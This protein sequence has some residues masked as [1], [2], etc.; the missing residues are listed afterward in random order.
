MSLSFLD[1]E[2]SRS[3]TCILLNSEPFVLVYLF[4]YFVLLALPF[5]LLFA[6]L[7][8]QI[9]LKKKFIRDVFVQTSFF[10]IILVEQTAS[11]LY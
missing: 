10:F 8:E 2:L 9:F 3:I 7:V 1:V 4:V 5:F 11:G 6:S